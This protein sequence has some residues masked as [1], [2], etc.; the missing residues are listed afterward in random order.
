MLNSAKKMCLL[1]LVTTVAGCGGLMSIFERESAALVSTAA[2]TVVRSE[3]SLTLYLEPVTSAPVVPEGV[4]SEPPM[5]EE[6]VVY[7]RPLAAELP[8]PEPMPLP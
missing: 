3:E 2:P 7:S 8:I 4:V 1:A 6:S 5:P